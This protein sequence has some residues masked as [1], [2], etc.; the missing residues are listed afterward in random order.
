MESAIKKLNVDAKDTTMS[1]HGVTNM[2]KRGDYQQALKEF[3]SLQLKNV[4][5][6]DTT[7]GKGI[8]GELGDGK[9]VLIRKGSKTGGATLEIQI[10]RRKSY[11][12]R[13]L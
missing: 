2:E 4:R 10:S 7:Y 6:I 3:N 8:M 12:V 5:E 13:Y 1:E 11:K 9:T